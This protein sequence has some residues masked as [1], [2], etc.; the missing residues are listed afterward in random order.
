MTY[1]LPWNWLVVS[2]C[3]QKKISDFFPWPSGWLLASLPSCWVLFPY[4]VPAPGTLSF[5]PQPQSKVVPA[6]GLLHMLFLLPCI[7]FPDIH[8]I[9][10]VGSVNEMVFHGPCPSIIFFIFRVD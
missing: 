3:F 4:L 1:A 7:L 10:I 9:P 5:S 6:S 8:M 2:Q